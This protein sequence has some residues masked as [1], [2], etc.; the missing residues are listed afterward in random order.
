M[1]PLVAALP[2]SME[3]RS[4]D[5]LRATLSPAR[6]EGSIL[7][8]SWPDA[9]APV[10]RKY[11]AHPVYRVE[12]GDI[13]GDG[14]ADVCVG[15]I[16]KTRFDPEPRRRLFLYT[17]DGATL[18]PLWLSSRLGM[19]LQIGQVV[20]QDTRQPVIT[21]ERE[22]RAGRFAVGI[23]KWRSFGLDFE[24][25]EARNLTRLESEQYGFSK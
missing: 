6:G 12:T 22:R 1:L 11:F 8:L 19:P 24:R 16:K 9:E 17:V 15:L 7:H 4:D 14:R 13:N 25:Y 2:H 10:C 3:S 18:R 5:S 21:L 20:G 23:W